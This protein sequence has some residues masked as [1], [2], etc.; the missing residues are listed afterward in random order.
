MRFR[1]SLGAVSSSAQTSA[2]IGVKPVEISGDNGLETFGNGTTGQL[3]GTSPP[4]ISHGIVR[5]LLCS[6]FWGRELR[7]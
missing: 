4:E 1:Y 3:S 2:Y 7:A 5:E 6:R